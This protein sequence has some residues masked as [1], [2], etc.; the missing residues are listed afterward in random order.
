MPAEVVHRGTLWRKRQY[1]KAVILFGRPQVCV[2]TS[3]RYKS[4]QWWY[5]LVQCHGTTRRTA[6]GNFNPV[7]GPLPFLRQVLQSSV[8]LL[9]SCICYAAFP[10]PLYDQNLKST[11]QPVKNSQSR[12]VTTGTSFPWSIPDERHSAQPDGGLFS[13]L[14]PHKPE[15]IK[16]FT[17]FCLLCHRRHRFSP[18]HS[19]SRIRMVTYSRPGRARGAFGGVGMV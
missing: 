17:P 11:G 12:H 16:G 7:A 10:L 9:S 4:V 19:P 1:S 13:C 18:L 14:S 6:R 5:K 15:A 2:H 3:C 8:L